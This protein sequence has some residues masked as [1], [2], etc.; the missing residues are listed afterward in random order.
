MPKPRKR[1]VSLSDT[2]YYHCISRCVR[3]AFLCGIDRQFGYSF[4]HRRHWTVE[5][6]LLLSSV[7]TIDVCA[8]TVMSNHYSVVLHVNSAESNIKF[9]YYLISKLKSLVN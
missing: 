9:R 4:E 8:Y 5:R 2:P 1:Q 3:R 6:I 7:F